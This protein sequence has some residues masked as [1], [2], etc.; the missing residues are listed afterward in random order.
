MN[1]MTCEE[2]PVLI[3]GGGPVGLAL[4]NELNYRNIRYVLVDEKDGQVTFPAGEAI[5]SRTMEHL[6]RWGLAQRAR[7][8]SEFPSDYP[9]NIGF[10]TALNG[11]MLAAFPG[12][13]NQE[14]PAA[15]DG[16][17]PEG[18]V[19]CPK[20]IFDPL[21]R[22][23]ALEKAPGAIRYHTRLED[24]VQDETGVTATLAD[25]D[26]GARST[27]RAQYLVACDGGHGQTRSKI[28]VK[29]A[30][31]FA[32][33]RNFAAFFR[34]PDLLDR[35]VAKYGAPFF[36]MHT[37]NTPRRP[38]LT[39]VDGKELWR[40]SMY[41]EEGEQI[42]PLPT[43]LASLGMDVQVE[44]I[45]AQPWTGHMVV[46]ER[47]GL[48]RVLLAGDAAHLRW[49]K[50]GFGANT[51]IGDAVDLGWKIAASLAGWGGKNLLASY[52]AERRPIAL[53]NTAE[54]ANN[55][56]LDQL[57]VADPELDSPTVQGEWTRAKMASLVNE[58]RRREFTT[59]GIQLGYRYRDSPI[60]CPDG[61][62]EPPDD[63]VDYKPSTWPG[64]RA[65]HAW[66]KDGVS[67]LDYYGQGFVLMSFDESI[68]T[69]AFT[70]GF[71]QRGV[72]FARHG[73]ASEQARKLYEYPL[74]LVRPDGHVAWR[75]SRAP[76]DIL[77]VVDRV[78]GA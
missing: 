75:G 36:Q 57:I 73:I 20:R 6:R 56:K 38:Y 47:Y 4:A 61:T 29:Y 55:Y 19:I 62:P 31:S 22:D 40:L 63:A 51:G 74:V 68:D 21:L 27:V 53:R 49:P 17:S 64:S 11:R 71:A 30:G 60:C 5:F 72:P 54:A 16:I 59:Q 28:G 14:I 8:P 34:S 41:V 78:R 44:I 1:T 39:T 76:D 43:V 9:L 26:T 3:V 58:K 67:T 35:I 65:P 24:F 2:I 66:V 77:Q 12:L 7:F 10:F 37:V 13:S 23:A 70:R 52:E 33:G 46:A 15:S 18:P 69:D 42:D 48:N 25:L 50:G 45:Q 32:Q